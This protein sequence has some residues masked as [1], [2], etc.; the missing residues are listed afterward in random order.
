[1]LTE[2][3][4]FGSEITQLNCFIVAPDFDSATLFYLKPHLHCIAIVLS[5]F[6]IFIGHLEFIV[7]F[8]IKLLFFM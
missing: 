6:F 5:I 8:Q 2:D 7:D 1:M 4:E 3:V